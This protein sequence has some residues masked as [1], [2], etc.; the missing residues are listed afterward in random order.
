[1]DAFGVD[2]LFQELLSGVTLVNS[3]H[4]HPL[5]VKHPRREPRRAASQEIAGAEEPG[6]HS[7]LARV[8]PV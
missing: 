7:Q 2:G 8:Q 6:K 4:P 3:P 1:M 5:P